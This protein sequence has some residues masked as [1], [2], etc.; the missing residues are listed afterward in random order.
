M[1]RHPPEKKRQN[2]TDGHTLISFGKGQKQLV[3]YL[4]AQG[5]DRFN[6]TQYS[7]QTGVSRSTIYDRLHALQ[8]KGIVDGIQTGDIRITTKGKRIYEANQGV[9]AV[10]RKGCRPGQ[11]S[12]HK[13]TY[14]IKI[15]D[16]TNFHPD[17][18]KQLGAE[19]WYPHR[20]PNRIDYQVHIGD[21]VNMTIMTNEVRIHIEDTVGQDVPEAEAKILERFW[22]YLTKIEDIGIITEGVILTQ[23]HY[24]RVLSTLSS[25]LEKIDHRYHIDLGDG[26][27]FW[28]DH[29][30][31]HRE[32]ES[33]DSQVRENVDEAIQRICEGNLLEQIDKNTENIAGLTK[34]AET[35]LKRDLIR[36]Q[37]PKPTPTDNTAIREYTG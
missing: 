2:P 5:K 10:P 23:S 8:S 16:K 26:R 24:A 35:M 30:E 28:I 4:I 27:K 36:F 9:S 19:S 21:G 3:G 20:L 15:K 25:A 1:N 11:L 18:L 33:N 6:V 32:D 34:I 17:K 31:G 22:D 12:I 13:N 29:S 37:T 7:R 14:R